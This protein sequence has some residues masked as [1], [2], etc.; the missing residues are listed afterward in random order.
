MKILFF[1]KEKCK[2]S[3]D[4]YK[5]LILMGHN[6]D[7]V[8]S[9][10]RGEKIPK[11]V[12]EWSGDYI[13]SFKNYFI[14]SQDTI[15]SAK[16]AAINFHP[17]LPFY[18]GSGGLNLS[19]YN[20]ESETG[21]TCHFMNGKIDQGDI[22][23]VDIIPIYYEDNVLSLSKRVDKQLLT[24]FK[25]I[26]R[27]IITE[28]KNVSMNKIRLLASKSLYK[29]WAKNPN[30]INKINRLREVDLNVNKEELT[31]II[32]ST[33]IGEMKPY[34]YIHGKKFVLNENE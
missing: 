4:A 25:K 30:S 18:P 7:V 28:K 13:L 1:C 6:I 24:T 15:N 10:K 8:Y 33:N 14:L 11:F 23:H 21:I 31:R 29:E 3:E 26:C 17:S 22:I 34:V 12:L 16:I 27:E 9:D 20:N 32:R 5:F 2:A 19:L